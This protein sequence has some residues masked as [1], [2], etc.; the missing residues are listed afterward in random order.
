MLPLFSID[1]ENTGIERLSKHKRF[2]KELQ[3]IVP[4]DMSE[5]TSRCSVAQFRFLDE[6]LFINVDV[7]K[8]GSSKYTVTLI[9]NG[10]YSNIAVNKLKSDMMQCLKEELELYITED[11]NVMIS[12]EFI[13]E[14]E[15]LRREVE[16]FDTDNNAA[17]IA[18]YKKVYNVWRTMINNLTFSVFQNG[19]NDIK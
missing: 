10:W 6:D 4:L 1:I 14:V 16:T 2:F 5:S 12:F 19:N 7:K 15:R 13:K 3:R 8:L 9:I 11:K 17:N 18:A